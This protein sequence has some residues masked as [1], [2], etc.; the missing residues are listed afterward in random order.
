MSQTYFSVYFPG[1]IVLRHV[2][3]GSIGNCWGLTDLL[4]KLRYTNANKQ[5]WSSLKQKS[6]V[7]AAV[8]RSY[9]RHTFMVM[10]LCHRSPL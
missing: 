10:T 7:R 3:S 9:E 2:H 1:N 4:E 6:T 8:L 5:N